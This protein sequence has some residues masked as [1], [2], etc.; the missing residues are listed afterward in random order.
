MHKMS[1]LVPSLQRNVVRYILIESTGISSE[2]EVKQNAVFVVFTLAYTSS[3]LYI[4]VQT[5]MYEPYVPFM[6][7]G[8]KIN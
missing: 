1:T 2:C 6:R 3:C 7:Q 8:L 4:K 5:Y